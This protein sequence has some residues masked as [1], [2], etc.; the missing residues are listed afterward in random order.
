MASVHAEISGPAVA[1][2]HLM[3]GKTTADFCAIL[4]GKYS[5]LDYN[6][7][8][9][10]ASRTDRSLTR[11][12]VEN[13]VIVKVEELVDLR[14]GILKQK[15]IV[16]LEW[17]RNL[18]FLGVLK[19][20]VRVQV[21]MLSY[22]DRKIMTAFYNSSF[23]VE[24]RPLLYVLAGHE[25]T[26]NTQSIKTTMTS[27]LVECKVRCRDGPWSRKVPLTV[28]NLGTGHRVEY[29][30]ACNGNKSL[31][32][33]LLQCLMIDVE[34]AFLPLLVKFKEGIDQVSENLTLLVTQKNTLL[35]DVEKLLQLLNQKMEQTEE[36]DL[37]RSLEGGLIPALQVLQMKS[38]GNVVMEE[39]T[40]ESLSLK[41]VL[42]EDEDM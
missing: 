29:L 11:M 1:N 31:Q 40:M 28:P 9:D 8:T 4:L 42:S 15:N 18:K 3:F 19:F 17:E 34:K 22:L 21:D 25:I 10:F 32:E 26:S 16:E 36:N 24:E 37:Y 33:E 12:V 7:S 38:K 41:L 20:G 14:T 35:N 30:T 6:E 27:F 23:L 2:F 5:V 39:K 13:L